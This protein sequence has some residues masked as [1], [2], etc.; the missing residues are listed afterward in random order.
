MSRLNVKPT[1][2]VSR[3]FGS[4]ARIKQYR[5]VITSAVCKSRAG[6]VSASASLIGECLGARQMVSLYIYPADL[7]VADYEEIPRYD[8]VPG[9]CQWTIRWR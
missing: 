3:P 4:M 2:A 9:R 8:R 7:V 6:W 5:S 1:M